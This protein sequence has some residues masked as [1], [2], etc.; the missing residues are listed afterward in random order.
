MTFEELNKSRELR[1][2]INQLKQTRAS[3][4]REFPKE[5][6]FDELDRLIREKRELRCAELIRLENYIDTIEDSVTRQILRGRF[7]Q[8]MSWEAVAQRIGNNTAEGV[9]SR[10]IR[11]INARNKETGG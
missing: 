5:S 11:Y 8:G 9:R 10:C 3:L 4:S 6:N 1:K 7:V 2:E